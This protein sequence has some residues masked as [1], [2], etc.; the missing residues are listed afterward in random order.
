MAKN[1]VA[2]SKLKY[3]HITISFEWS[4]FLS[5]II[6]RY[7]KGYQTKDCPADPSELTISRRGGCRTPADIQIH[8]PSGPRHQRH[9]VCIRLCL[10]PVC[11]K[12]PL[13]HLQYPLLCAQRLYCSVQG[14]ATR[15]TIS[16]HRM[17]SNALA[18]QLADF[19]GEEPKDNG[20]LTMVVTGPCRKRR[21]LRP[22][23][24][25]LGIFVEEIQTQNLQ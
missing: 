17:F 11:L 3:I 6:K 25:N 5:N 16:V 1:C 10:A 18:P 2:M 24:D 7:Q 4:Q 22:P 21:P 14:R 12:T 8:A 23:W 13:D 20:K 15:K 19:T 9:C